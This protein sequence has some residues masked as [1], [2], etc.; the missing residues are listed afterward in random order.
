M[1]HVQGVEGSAN[2]GPASRDLIDSRYA[3]FRLVV[4]LLL[5]TIGNG[6]MY[7]VVV[8]LPV[9]QAEFGVAR[10]VASLPYT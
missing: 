1:A 4:A 6:G 2:H 9:V 5:M 8:V 3:V 10:A 7:M